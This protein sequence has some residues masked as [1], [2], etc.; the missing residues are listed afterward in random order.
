MIET[1][2]RR[3]YVYRSVRHGTQVRRQYVGKASDPHARHIAQLLTERKHEHEHRRMVWQCLSELDA[4]TKTAHRRMRTIV[5]AHYLCRGFHFTK[6]MWRR[7]TNPARKGAYDRTMNQLPSAG[8]TGEMHATDDLEIIV[9]R[10]MQG[11]QDALPALR[12]ALAQYPTIQ[13]TFNLVSRTER[14][15]TQYL[16]GTDLL[17]TELLRG[18]LT[19]L[20]ESLLTEGSSALERLCI[21]TLALDWLALMAARLRAAQDM[22]AYG[23]LTHA[24]E[25]LMNGA[26]KRFLASI[27]EL[28]RLRRLLVPAA[29]VQ[30]NVARTQFNSF[31][32]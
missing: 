1:R 22:K 19:D 11:D 13:D 27:R 24:Q 25:T 30:I 18:Q 2:E 5:A 14:T 31:L 12:I 17:A 8:T 32:D 9:T 6:R 7:L 10:A 26:Q 16:A 20:K 4:E 28:A 23:R 29:K 3:T 21:E 15:W